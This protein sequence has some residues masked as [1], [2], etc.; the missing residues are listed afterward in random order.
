MLNFHIKYKEDVTFGLKHFYPFLNSLEDKINDADGF[1][2][3]IQ[4]AG[5]RHG[6]LNRAMKFD[7]SE[8]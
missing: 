1:G 6:V 3:T 7:S 8:G 4:R 2:Y 5:D